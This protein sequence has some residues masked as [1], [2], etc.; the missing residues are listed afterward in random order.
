MSK[1]RAGLAV[2]VPGALLL[3]CLTAQA[4]EP[5][6]AS[7]AE[8]QSAEQIAAAIVRTA[9]AVDLKDIE[10]LAREMPSFAV[11]V[12][13]LAGRTCLNKGQPARAVQ[14]Y[15]QALRVDPEDTNTV[16]ALAEAQLATGQTT[17]AM[18][19][20]RS[21]AATTNDL[22]M[23][24][25]YA[26]FLDRA[27]AGDAAIDLMRTLVKEWP[28]QASLRYWIADA[29][30]RQGKPTEAAKELR[31]MLKAFPEEA[32]EISRRLGSAAPSGAVTGQKR[33][34]SGD[35]EDRQ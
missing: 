15:R 4:A 28:Q 11:Q 14:M 31:E 32:A 35:K 6:K 12:Y 9:K 13:H 22:G 19:T 16:E 8:R 30:V 5:A 34:S 26:A 7:P 20:W 17:E 18:A 21:L 33:V 1:P 2:V 27:G 24:I 3:A 29:Y 25:R 23:R 10:A